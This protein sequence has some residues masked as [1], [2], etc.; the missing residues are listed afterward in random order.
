MKDA[1]NEP[2]HTLAKERLDE[3]A[4][5]STVAAPDGNSFA[6]GQEGDHGVVE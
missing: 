5:R 2:E 1:K 3:P 4:T 6:D